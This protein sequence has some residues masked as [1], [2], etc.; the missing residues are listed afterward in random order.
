MAEDQ[1][2]RAPTKD[3]MDAIADKAKEMRGLEEKVSDLSDQ[4]DSVKVDLHRVKFTELPDLMGAIGMTKFSVE[5]YGNHPAFDIKSS[6]YCRAS[7]PVDM[8]PADRDDAFNYLIERGGGDLIKTT[9]TF[10]F[11]K[12]SMNEVQ[13]FL[14]FVHSSSDFPEPTVK[15]MVHH[16]SL[17][18]WLKEE[19]AIAGKSGGI[20]PDLERLNATAGRMAEIKVKK[21]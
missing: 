8:D 12:D 9:V 13:K 2:S 20:L 11:G 5:A 15:M 17:S 3:R 19:M 1:V 21:S 6:P 14:D 18:S 10:E 7:I 16:M 4:L